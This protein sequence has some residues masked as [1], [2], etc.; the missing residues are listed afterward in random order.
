M[1]VQDSRSGRRWEDDQSGADRP[2]SEFRLNIHRHLTHRWAN[3]RS[4]ALDQIGTSSYANTRRAELRAIPGAGYLAEQYGLKTAKDATPRDMQPGLRIDNKHSALYQR[5]KPNIKL[6]DKCLTISRSPDYRH[7]LGNT[8]FEKNSGHMLFTNSETNASRILAK[9]GGNTTSRVESL[10]PGLV[11]IKFTCHLLAKQA[12]G[13]LIQLG[14]RPSSYEV[15]KLAYTARTASEPPS[16]LREGID[17]HKTLL[18]MLNE[19]GKGVISAL[20]NLPNGHAMQATANCT[21]S[22]LDGLLKALAEKADA[23]E[24]KH[25]LLIA[26]VLNALTNVARA[27][28]TLTEDSTRFFAGYDAML[29]SPSCLEPVLHLFKSCIQLAMSCLK[30]V[31]ET[32]VDPHS[33]VPSAVACHDVLP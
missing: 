20:K 3:D 15:G 11:A 9:L 31:V 25:D 2:V 18:E 10:S 1:R 21:A 6:Q 22:L 14:G 7:L 16:R 17:N 30:V 13:I 28:P 23:P 27:L 4:A 12:E 8:L 19:E 24:F 5:D 33:H 29:E 32:I 26:N